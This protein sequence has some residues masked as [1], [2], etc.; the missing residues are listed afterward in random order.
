MFLLI[1]ASGVGG[2]LSA[3]FAL[4]GDY[5]RALLCLAIACAFARDFLQLSGRAAHSHTHWQ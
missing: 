4:H 1:L 2:L 3:A 5:T